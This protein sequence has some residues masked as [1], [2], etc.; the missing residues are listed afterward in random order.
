[1]SEAAQLSGLPLIEEVKG[2]E[3]LYRRCPAE[4]LGF[5]L[6]DFNAMLGDVLRRSFPGGCDD[7]AREAFLNSLRLNELVLARACVRGHEKAWER[8]L[9]LYREKLYRMAT[10]IAGQESIGRELA[11]SLYGDL[12]GTR[13]GPD[14]QRISKLETYTGRGSLEGWLRIVL[15]Q[16]YVNRHRSERRHISFEDGIEV[17]GK[18]SFHS[19]PQQREL[20]EAT[21]LV[22]SKLSSEERFVLA[23][24][25]LDG[26]TLAELGAM[27]GLHESTMSRRLE[28]LKRDV[29][30]RIVEQLC[31]QGICRR[32][33]EEM[34]DTDVRDLGVDVRA[35]L[36]QG[37]R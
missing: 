35:R 15:S 26:R 36:A 18:Y 9:F 34:L 23:A 25:Y 7:R 37:G 33:A 30:H 5:T 19:G 11:D 22:L 16:E 3:R 21:D 1:V 28:K 31:S 6:C 32:A 24:Y 4:E 14:G 29:R 17:A 27:L 10:G 13:T 2:V 12:F 20:D 8:F